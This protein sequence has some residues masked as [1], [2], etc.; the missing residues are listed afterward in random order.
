LLSSSFSN[1]VFAAPGGN[2]PER[3]SFE[4]RF[5][6]LAAALVRLR[7]RTCPQETL[8]VKLIRTFKL[9]LTFAALFTAT[10]IAGVKLA[11]Q[12]NPP[13]AIASAPS[14]NAPAA[15]TEALPEVDTETDADLGAGDQVVTA[16]AGPYG[17][18][19]S[20]YRFPASVDPD[21]LADA[22][23]ELWARVYWPAELERA[24]KSGPLPILFFLHGN[25]STCGSNTNPRHDSGCRYTYE[26]R[27]DAG[28]VVVPNHQGFNYLGKHFAS[29]GYIAVSINANRG[30]TCS[31]GDDN[32]SG[33]I[34]ARGRLILRHIE[35]WSK[36]V[37][38]G[39]EPVSAK[40]K[41]DLFKGRV[42]LQNIGLMGHS[43]GGEGVRAAF[44]LLR[45]PGA[46]WL[47]RLP[48]A[49][50]KGIFEIGA[51]DGQSIRTLDAD[52]VAWNGLIPMCDGDVTGMEGRLPFERMIV[53]TRELRKTPKSLYLV[54]GA[55]H[56]FFNTQWFENDSGGCEDHPSIY[57]DGTRS[58]AQQEIA[59]A[60]M[61]DFFRAHVGSHRTYA[62]RQHFDP[63]FSLPAPV[64]AITRVDR[65]HT[66]TPDSRVSARLDDFDQQTGMSSNKQPNEASG[67]NVSHESAED[68][69]HYAHV[70]WE[71]PNGFMQL[72]WTETGSGRD[73]ATFK[74]LDF[75]VLRG[76]THIGQKTPTDFSL[77]LI[78]ANNQ[79]SRKI[80]VSQ[81]AQILGPVTENMVF[82][83]VRVPLAEFTGV[84]QASIRGVRFTFDVSS[85][86]SLFFANV[87]FST[88]GSPTNENLV[89]PLLAQTTTLPFLLTQSQTSAVHPPSVQSSPSKLEEDRAMVVTVKVRSRSRQLSTGRVVDLGI[90]ARTHFPVTNA[91]PVL[92]M[93]GK[94]FSTSHY[95]KDGRLDTLVFSVPERDYRALPEQGPMIVQYG[96][97][98]PH[99]LW[100]LPDYTKSNLVK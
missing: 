87:R 43:R 51:V 58:V 39:G 6:K 32:D 92:V 80:P 52:D 89:T 72:N 73:L 66:Y 36:W 69:A 28:D 17:F 60:A 70:T 95:P 55:N 99:K 77:Q 57:G 13:G 9:P 49:R 44:N 88:D 45:D 22:K 61:S 25:H 53:K 47:A 83:T 78:D 5:P 93:G 34:L 7:L 79:P 75:R 2:K 21:V 76:P 11:A 82:Q 24:A 29:L 56:N 63:H 67:V 19:S 33:L 8:T 96:K 16:A 64:T 98:S 41:P 62:L 3:L 26:G 10:S 100:R 91:L 35:L 15:T 74:Y 23:T 84:N 85:S 86:G 71:S 20:E 30:I 18:A 54:W 90:R 59:L 12:T 37:K 27:C 14:G 4:V 38:S 31:S 40:L 50:I 46:P 94:R 1:R 48:Q 81:F 68:V 42:D 65:A 97:V